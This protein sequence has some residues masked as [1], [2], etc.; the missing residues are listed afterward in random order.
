MGSISTKTPGDADVVNSGHDSKTFQN[1]DDESKGKDKEKDGH[2]A[3]AVK[4]LED[5]TQSNVQYLY[6]EDAKSDLELQN[7]L[8]AYQVDEQEYRLKAFSGN[9]TVKLFIHGCGGTEK[10]TETMH[11][12]CSYYGKEIGRGFGTFVNRPYIKDNFLPH[13]VKAS[14]ELSKIAFEVFDRKGCLKRK[15]MH[16]L[17][18]E[19]TGSGRWGGELDNG[20]LL[21]IEYVHVAKIWRRKGVGK[22]MIESLTALARSRGRETAFTLVR[23]HWLSRNIWKDTIG[24]TDQEQNKVR[25]SARAAATFF[26][27]CLGFRRI[28]SSS[29][30]AL[31]TDPYLRAHMVSAAYDFDPLTADVQKDDPDAGYTVEPTPKDL[32]GYLAESPYHHHHSPLLRHAAITLSDT[33]CVQAY[34]HYKRLLCFED[35]W[36]K[37][38]CYHDNVLH[39]AACRLKFRTVQW[40]L[41]NA[42]ER[43]VLSS[44]K[45]VEGNT[46]LEALESQ[47]DSERPS[48][49]RTGSRIFCG[50]P[51]EAIECLAALRGIHGLTEIQILRLKFGCTC[52]EC[53]DGVISPRIRNEALIRAE[54]LEVD[55]PQNVENGQIEW[56]MLHMDPRIKANFISTIS[57]QWGFGKMYG[58]IYTAMAA[59][60]LPT[61]ENILGHWRDS[62]EPPGPTASFYGI[63]GIAAC[64]LRIIF[65]ELR[66]DDMRCEVDEEFGRERIEDLSRF[67]P[68]RNDREFGLAAWVCG[69]SDL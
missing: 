30:F 51:M 22:R 15:F 5:K 45:N 20:T 25:I 34:I 66:R 67:P 26:F 9:I 24:R 57:L 14:H 29:C 27:R 53:I 32:F 33:E 6:E 59:D 65:E 63:G 2:A 62:G 64:A 17:V 21:I 18:P 16:N 1:L 10:F 12:R 40:L 4:D 3:N 50:F 28:G 23:P 49:E 43:Q 35:V 48:T 19:C 55:V 60:E 41:E 69:V 39:I 52:G 36:E 42:N 47:L 61:V 38:D 54:N 56:L 13:M 37:V 11:V 7:Y 44:A 31:P 46:P 8:T 58:H 68:C